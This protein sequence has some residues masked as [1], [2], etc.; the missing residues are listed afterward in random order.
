[1]AFILTVTLAALALIALGA[2]GALA[3]RLRSDLA[4]ARAEIDTL[5]ARLAA[6]TVWAGLGP[7]WSEAQALT[8]DLVSRPLATTAL[9]SPDFAAPQ[10]WLVDPPE[11]GA[12]APVQP[13]TPA[14]R[15][16]HARRGRS[17]RRAL[18]PDT[19]ESG[20]FPA[21][22]ADAALA[23]IDVSAAQSPAPG[24]AVGAAIGGVYALTAA[25]GALFGWPW[26]LTLS[27][28][29]VF[30]GLMAAGF[31]RAEKPIGL[32]LAAGMAGAAPW[33]AALIGAPLAVMTPIAGGLIALS[34][35][36]GLGQRRPAV[37]W[38]AA[39]LTGGG[40]A[41][42][43]GLEA[44]TGGAMQA[45]APAAITAA[46][47]SALGL[48][49]AVA[50]PDAGSR[51]AASALHAAALAALALGAALIGIAGPFGWALA[52]AAALT[53]ALANGPARDAALVSAWLAACVGLFALS[54]DAAAA[55]AMTPAAALAGAGF[56]GAGL[57]RTPRPEGHGL[58]LFALA[59]AAPLAAVPLALT[60]P[61]AAL[62]FAAAGALLGLGFAKAAQAQGGAD[63]VTLA[64]WPL[65]L[66]AA[67]GGCAALTAAAPPALI[68]P[69]AGAAALSLS[70][71][72]AQSRAGAVAASAAAV[73]AFAVVAVLDAVRLAP[74]A[75]ATWTG[76]T[77]AALALLTGAWLA[78]TRRLGGAPA[79]GVAL[80]AAG[81][82]TAITAP[83]GLFPTAALHLQTAGGVATAWLAVGVLLSA[84]GDPEGEARRV[85]AIVAALGAALAGL[86]L[87]VTANPWWS[88]GAA[89]LPA[90]SAGAAL[91][92][93]AGAPALLSGAMAT[94]AALRRE[95]RAGAA[96][97]AVAVILTLAGTALALRSVAFGP[98][99]LTEPGFSP[100]ELIGLTVTMAA[101][102]AGLLLTPSRTARRAG[103]ALLAAAA[104]KF[105]L[106]DLHAAG[107]APA[108]ASALAGLVLLAAAIAGRGQLRALWRAEASAARVGLRAPKPA[109]P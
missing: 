87:L 41:A 107:L 79:T 16:A 29:L 10:A 44:V 92:L 3:L 60:G 25:A 96:F 84:L 23:G 100:L 86:A 98:A 12:P 22:S 42:M 11:P 67:A 31:W 62:G 24:P 26:A 7:E 47:L 68:G 72:A 38:T 89:P 61:A 80:A 109:S 37:I 83:L 40:A 32:C 35:L 1:M 74:E 103:L 58:V 21:W 27:L 51:R 2:L 54:G 65:A 9:P 104:A 34:A 36:I 75:P 82:V 88:A 52:V 46:T 76:A 102:G 69:L 90:G 17:V 15:T 18:D 106:L 49:Q 77:M 4:A 43:A 45:A 70:L 28:L 55:V 91:L 95:R 108:L 53:L 57:A 20:L 14:P 50:A 97:G 19:L 73:A 64:A 48:L 81:V 8:A 105:A 13:A 93:G 6:P 5:K 39:V 59:A 66:G 71:L 56:L 63:Q 33:I 101:L 99:G 85:G 30:A 78:S 94:I